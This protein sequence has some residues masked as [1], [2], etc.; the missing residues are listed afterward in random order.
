M[1][2]TFQTLGVSPILC[3][4]LKKR[5]IAVPT[6]V[7]EKALPA[8]F[9]GRDILGQAQTGTGKTLAFLLPALQQIHPDQHQEQVLILAPTRE[10]AK[11]ITAVAT[12][13]AAALHIDVLNIIGGQ[14]IENQLQ[15]LQRHPQVIIGTPG[16]LLD[17]CRRHSLNLTGVGRI[18]VDEADQLLQTGFLEDVDTLLDMTPKRRQL[19]FFSATVPDKIKSLAK[20][21]CTIRSCF[22][23]WKE[24]VL[25]WKLLNNAYT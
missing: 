2:T 11:Q 10:L 1:N 20:N 15:K 21:I 3:E 17:H 25:L 16:R 22:M 19:L 4:L 23:C 12:D 14:T 5:G 18:I 7:Q 13:L 8:L 6:Q 24:A 9:Q